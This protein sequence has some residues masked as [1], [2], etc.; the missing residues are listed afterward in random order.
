MELLPPEMILYIN[1]VIS[2]KKIIFFYF[3]HIS[4]VQ[5]TFEFYVAGP[6][7]TSDPSGSLLKDGSSPTLDA[8]IQPTTGYT[9]MATQVGQQIIRIFTLMAIL[10]EAS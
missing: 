5:G 8:Q 2:N 3:N 7:L 6:A 1:H 4:L 9:L 10:R